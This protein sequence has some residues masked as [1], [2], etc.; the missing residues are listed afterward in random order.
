MSLASYRTAPPR[1]GRK[2]QLALRLVDVP[3]SGHEVKARRAVKGIKTWIEQD[4]Q[5]YA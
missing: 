4:F 2:T 1:A 5:P 3:T